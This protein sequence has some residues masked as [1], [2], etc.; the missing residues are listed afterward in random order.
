MD[1]YFVGAFVVMKLYYLTA[2]LQ[3]IEYFGQLYRL[4][5]R[6]KNLHT[7]RSYKTRIYFTKICIDWLS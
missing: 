7:E 3:Y 2:I 6:Q 1:H 4:R 5:I